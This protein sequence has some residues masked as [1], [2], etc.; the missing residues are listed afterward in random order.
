MTVPRNPVTGNRYFVRLDF[1]A[2]FKSGR[3]EF[4]FADMAGELRG[5]A[6]AT[7]D[8]CGAVIAG[9]DK[10]QV[11][12]AAGSEPQTGAELAARLGS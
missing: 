9:P 1:G 10:E 4:T 6:W 3:Q 12:R 11:A 5:E 2:G 7:L 8:Y